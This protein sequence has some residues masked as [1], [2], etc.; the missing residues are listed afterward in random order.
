M[1]AKETAQT[2][3]NYL[4]TIPKGERTIEAAFFGGSFTG[5]SEEKQTD[6]LKAAYEFVKR[7][8]IDGIRLST[9][10]DYISEE[11]L[12]RLQKYGVT[13]I[14]LGVQSM[15]DGVLKASGRGHKKEAVISAVSLIKKYPFKLGLQMMTGLPKDNAEKSVK[16][17][18]QIIALKP[19]FVRIYPTLV[20][21]DTY[22]EKMYQKGEY[23]PWSVDETVSVLKT[24]IPMFAENNIEIIRVALSVTEEIAPG[25]SLV[26]G[27][28]H[29]AIR[30]L[31]EGEIYFEKMCKLL[32][33]DTTI[34]A[35]SVNK[36]EVSKAV[37]N[38]KRNI[39][40]IEEK[41][42]KKIKIKPSPLLKKGEIA[43]WKE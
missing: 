9:R 29:P 33:K 26:A 40:R 25:A 5:I 27:P 21:K 4:D 37:G 20:L 38:G 23:K 24:I 36:S 13:T 34:S 39:N 42:G 22:L 2:I 31:A 16:T 10:P 7:G 3:K 1:T 32:D 43:A 41:Y 19:D 30:E 18:E 8:E 17:A 35:F 6:L 14:E 12:E 11:I 15:D 28:F